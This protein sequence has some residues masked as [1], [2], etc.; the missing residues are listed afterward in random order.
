MVYLGDSWFRKAELELGWAEDAQCYLY[1]AHSQLSYKCEAHSQLHYSRY[2][3]YSQLRYGCGLTK[4]G[5][6]VILAK[7]L[8]TTVV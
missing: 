1:E 4:T 2:K 3:R 8:V 5:K 7:Y 6:V